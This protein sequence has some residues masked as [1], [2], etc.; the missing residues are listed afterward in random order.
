MASI[1]I[2]VHDKSPEVQSRSSVIMTNNGGDSF[3]RTKGVDIIAALIFVDP[4]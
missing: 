4:E 2:K 3:A 1:S